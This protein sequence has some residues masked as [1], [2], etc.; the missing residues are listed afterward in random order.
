MYVNKT[1]GEAACGCGY[2]TIASPCFTSLN[3]PAVSYHLAEGTAWFS[4]A[5]DPTVLFVW[6]VFVFVVVVLFCVC[7]LG[8]VFVKSPLVSYDIR[9][10]GTLPPSITVI[11]R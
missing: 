11:G 4:A 8:W 7:V 6:F 3:C 9:A 5:S 2:I 1:V 10:E